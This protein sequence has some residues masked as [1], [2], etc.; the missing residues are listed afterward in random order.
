MKLSDLFGLVGRRALVTGGTSGIGMAI[1][2]AYLAAGADVVVSSDREDECVTARNTLQAKGNLHA[3][4]LRLGTREAS[5]T[6]VEEASRVLGGPID[7]LVSNAGIEGPVG[8]TGSAAQD[9]IDDLFRVNVNAAYW[10]AAAVA[11]GMRASGGGAMIFMA[12]IAA[13]RGNRVIGAY[14]MTK[15]ALTQLARNLAVEHG[16]GNIRANAIAPGLIETPFARGLMSDAA[17]MERRL[18]ATPLRR[19]GRPDEVAATAL[20]LASPGGAFT[21]GQVIVVDGGTLIAD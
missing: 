11:P 10:L 20:W 1:A 18:A 8:A 7:I 3:L 15:A 19:V 12:S 9:E 13:L 5:E 14:G 21:N 4:C 2:R 17:F 16:P 6:L